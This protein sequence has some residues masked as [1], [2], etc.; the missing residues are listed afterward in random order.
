M[1][2]LK[3]VLWFSFFV[4]HV[5]ATQLPAVFTHWLEQ[6]TQDLHTDVAEEYYQTWLDKAQ[7]PVNLNS[8]E[9]ENL[10]D[11]PFLSYRQI[12]NILE[13]RYDRDFFATPYELALV[14]EMDSITIALLLPFVEAKPIDTQNTFSLKNSLKNASH[15]VTSRFD[16]TF[17]PD[18]AY[19]QGKYLGKPWAG[20]INYQLN[21]EHISAGL[22]AQKNAYE[23]FTL[24]HNAG[25]DFYSG[26]VAIKN[27]GILKQLVIGDYSATFGQGLVLGTGSG[28]S[29]W[30]DINSLGK[31]QNKLYAKKKGSEQLYLRGLG[32]TL[33]SKHWQF[34]ALGSVK[35]VDEA[36]GLHQTTVELAKK[37][38]EITYMVGG[39]VL[40]NY[41][42]IKVGC[43]FMYDWFTR[44][45]FIGLDY[46]THYKNF[47]FSGEIACNHTGKIATVNQVTIA[48]HSTLKIGLQQRYYAPCYNQAFGYAGSVESAFKQG[49]I[50]C[51]GT[52][53]W[54]VLPTLKWNMSADISKKLS[55]QHR[56]NRSSMVYKTQVS[57]TYQFNQTQQLFC[58][59]QWSKQER[60]ESAQNQTILPTYAYTKHSIQLQY[61][62]TLK[63]G[64]QL[65]SGWVG[66][67]FQYQNQP[68]CMGHLV[69]Q[70]I[71]FKNN[72]WQIMGRLCF[73][74]IPDY[75]NKITVYE[76]DVL[77]AFSNTGYYGKGIRAYVNIGYKPHPLWGIY[78]KAA[79]TYYTDNIH[80]IPHQ[81]TIH[82]V[83]QYTWKKR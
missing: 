3:W 8:V 72:Q 36:Q 24:P 81:T 50:G 57:G 69:F 21:Q 2:K 53:E 23:P 80:E 28:F 39:N 16:Y 6:Y 66:R 52:V 59:W 15:T 32:I 35:Q 14:E 45:A 78:L 73:F 82:A 4:N 77:Y 17:Q 48:L 74:D 83:I 7:H 65:K 27:C 56:I 55:P 64:L 33:Q 11:F 51:Y 76:N 68:I 63:Q 60:N 34:S 43:S 30:S 37:Q 71:G 25:F 38:G 19:L 47:L 70:D 49:E 54:L 26:H 44:L 13:Y 22:T 67:L 18:K 1:E 29:H 10:E 75:D 42:H 46:R 9:R 62:G 5:Y 79:H 31:R 20:Y 12:E 61:N 41:A 40:A 58:K